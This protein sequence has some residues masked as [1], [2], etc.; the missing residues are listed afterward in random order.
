VV[1]VVHLTAHLGGGVGKALSGL[2]AHSDLSIERTIVC[3]ERPERSQF[4][5]RLRTQVIVCP[6]ADTLARLVEGADIVQLEWWNHPAII[7]CLCSLPNSPLRLLVWCHVS[8]LF[9]PIVPLGLI[10]AARMFTFTSTCSYEATEV[11]KLAPGLLERLLVVPSCGG[12]EGF[13]EPR[14]TPS[15]RF[16]VGY[17]G[18]LNFAKLHPHYVEF[19]AAVDISGFCVSILGDAI[20]Q[21][22]LSAQCDSMGKS[23]ILR[24]L[25]YTSDVATALRQFDVLAYLL[26][27]THYGTT[28]NALLEAMSMGIVP[29]VLDNPAERRIV[30]DRRPGLIVHSPSEFSQAMDWLWR[31]PTERQ[32][33]GE[34]AGRHVREKY[35]VEKTG[36]SFDSL[37]GA[38]LPKE[39]ANVD[40]RKIF[41]DDPADWF[42]ACQGDGTIFKE[43]GSTAVDANSL[44]VH[45]L[46]ERSKGSV[47]HFLEHF[48]NDVKLKSWAASLQ[49]C[50][51]QLLAAH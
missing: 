29:V 10:G 41:G 6:S 23:G 37:Y 5:D 3:L 22:V 13:P 2:A 4:V 14:S 21:D 18:S 45:S 11:C 8:G 34:R 15:A 50:R 51:S 12:F 28:E 16:S 38:I 46:F 43:D 33:I 30:D 42:L 27:P 39:K 36:K 49:Q 48:P 31:N 35:A 40:F 1:K 26:N 17:I 25:G 20:N 32:R 7:E 19:L 24:F 9:N 44:L 47:F